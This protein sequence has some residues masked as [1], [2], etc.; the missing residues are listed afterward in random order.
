V[1]A[2]LIHADRRTDMTKVTTAFGDYKNAPK[3]DH[4]A[5]CLVLS[6][7]CQWRSS[8]KSYD[9]T[10]VRAVNSH[11]IFGRQYFAHFKVL[12]E[13]SFHLKS[14]LKCSTDH[15]VL[16]PFRDVIKNSVNY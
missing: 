6:E 10:F 7:R 13:V 5:G 14:L 8:S 15:F 1:E 9:V 3:N 11:R 4:T 2:A 16:G 12:V